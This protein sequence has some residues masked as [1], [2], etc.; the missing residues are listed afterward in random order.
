MTLFLFLLF[1]IAIGAKSAGLD[2]FS[3]GITLG[4]LG[5]LSLLHIHM[6]RKMF[7]PFHNASAA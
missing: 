7:A 6:L 5:I 4:A 2:T 1:G 3:F